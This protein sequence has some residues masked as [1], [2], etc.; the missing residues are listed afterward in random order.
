MHFTCPASLSLHGGGGGSK[1]APDIKSQTCTCIYLI[2]YERRFERTA[3][4]DFL[5]KSGLEAR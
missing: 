5:E 3:E 1:A 2:H 4:L